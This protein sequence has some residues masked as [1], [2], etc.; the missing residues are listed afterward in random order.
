[1]DQ[2]DKQLLLYIHPKHIFVS[3]WISNFQLGS[4]LMMACWQSWGTDSLFLRDLV[5]AG[6][7]N[8]G[9]SGSTSAVRFDVKLWRRMALISVFA[10]WSLRACGQARK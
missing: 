7:E 5:C 6:G 2:S 1:M 8:A 10:R 3:A 4:F 9:S